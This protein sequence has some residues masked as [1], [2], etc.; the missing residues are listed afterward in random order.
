[1]KIFHGLRS[2]YVVLSLTLSML[3][4]ALFFLSP[5]AQAIGTTGPDPADF[6]PNTR[7]I[8]LVVSRTA[9]VNNATSLVK[10]YFNQPS[11][12]FR[13]EDY[14]LCKQNPGSSGNYYD[15][16]ASAAAGANATRYDIYNSRH[17]YS[18]N[19]ETEDLGPLLTSRDGIASNAATCKTVSSTFNV[20]GLSYSQ[21]V[22]K[23]VAYV[24]A[25]NLIAGTQNAFRV[26][27]TTN[28]YAVGYDSTIAASQFGINQV[29]PL[30][31]YTDYL[32]KFAGDCTL[33]S[34]RSEE[35]QWY[36]DDNGA[37]GIQP[38]PMRFQLRKYPT[39]GGPYTLQPFTSLKK[40]N[41]DSISWSQSGGWYTAYS[42]S[43]STVAAKFVA[44]PGYRY[45]WYWDNVYYNNTM[46]FKLAFDSIY[47][48][49][50]CQR[51][52][53]SN[54]T[55]SI[56]MK[57]N[58]SSAAANAT[59]EVGDTVDFTYNVYNNGNDDSHN[60]NCTIIG[61]SHNGYYN[62]GGT[63]D[64]TSDV[65]YAPPGT[66][67]PRDFPGKTTTNVANED[68]PGYKVRASDTNKTICRTFTVNPYKVGGGQRGVIVCFT[69]VAKPYV[70]V[71]GGDT[72]VG[73]GFAASCTANPDASITTWNKDTLVSGF[74]GAGGQYGVFA[75]DRI[76]NYASAQ[77]VGG[78]AEPFGL[79][80]AN[81][82]VGVG[83]GFYGGSFSALPCVKDY[84]AD[85][86][87]DAQPLSLNPT[88][89]SLATGFHTA[90]SSVGP[91]SVTIGTS[92][93]NLGQRVVL[94]VQGDV[95]ITGN[96][97]YPAGYDRT[98]MPLFE[99]IV[100]GN[101]YI[102]AGV[103]RL[104]GAYIVQKNTASTGVAYTCTTAAAPLVPDATL[105]AKCKGKKLTINGLLSAPQIMLLRTFGTLA[106]STSGDSSAS[107]NAA[108]VIN[109][110]PTM[111]I[112]QPPSSSNNKAGKY[113]SITS[114]P[115]VL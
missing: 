57:V 54:L 36:D 78:A 72:S 50:G 34:A 48:N 11:G 75:L 92:N 37:S 109:Y 42:G 12:S 77:N 71:F 6:S 98:T 63:L 13:I 19:A 74:A 62:P 69:V 58:G 46:Q 84:F 4:G 41:G 87:S 10:I 94:Y 68:S 8:E 114:L 66:G 14:L 112:A 95:H 25:T 49:T 44:E 61:K 16:D 3:G 31:G 22:G 15:V 43:K 82:G 45:I 18:G 17:T 90:G 105:N 47:F 39:S 100:K 81:K 96:I 67:C 20:S 2:K 9:D 103:D 102:D 26:V 27:V 76:H 86:P 60:T 80:F 32:L 89:S 108:E 70:K 24:R 65:G 38:S 28:G 110:N 93:V 97:T 111:W 88:I 113:D 21:D 33:T 23:Y 107:N 7:R 52:A 56:L 73:N 64:T 51:P 83:S 53:D 115:P 99:L 40:T 106:N 79:S 35:L 5:Q 30:N 59:A 85:K 104:D 91:A 1:M 55:P 29:N 101:L